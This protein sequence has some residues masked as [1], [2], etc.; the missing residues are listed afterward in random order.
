MLKKKE[1]SFEYLIRNNGLRCAPIVVSP[2]LSCFYDREKAEPVTLKSNY[3]PR[4]ELSGPTNQ[5][6]TTEKKH[7]AV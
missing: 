4:P 2:Q 3:C 1:Q 7:N 5:S 6:K